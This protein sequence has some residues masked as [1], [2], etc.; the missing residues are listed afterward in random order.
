[1]QQCSKQNSLERIKQAVHGIAPEA[2]IVLYGSRARSDAHADSEWDFL[3]LPEG[4]V[5]DAHPD[6]IHHTVGL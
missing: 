5:D 3:I 6:A 2:D 4:V 1:V